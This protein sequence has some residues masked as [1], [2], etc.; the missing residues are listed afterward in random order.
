MRKSFVFAAAAVLMMV[1][2]QFASAAPASNINT[3]IQLTTDV[4]LAQYYGGGYGYGY[5]RPRYYR[6]YYGGYGGYGGYGRGYY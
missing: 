4:Q 1:G 5:R 6:P 3:T 2:P